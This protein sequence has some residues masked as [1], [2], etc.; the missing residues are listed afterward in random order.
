MEPST[1]MR[2]SRIRLTAIAITLS[3]VCAIGGRADDAAP[4]AAKP[5]AVYARVSIGSAS[6]VAKLADDLGIPLPAMLTAGGVEQMFPF[7]GQGGLNPDLPVTMDFVGDGTNLSEAER[8]IWYLPI[9]TGK[10]PISDFFANGEK[11]GDDGALVNGTPFRRT[12]DYLMFG[13][14]RAIMAATKPADMLKNVSDHPLFYA[15]Y[16]PAKFHEANPQLFAQMRNN[17]DQTTKNAANPGEAAGSQMATEFFLGSLDK[18]VFR[19]DRTPEALKLAAQ[20][21]PA[22]QFTAK[23]WPLPGMPDGMA[24]RI[25]WQMP[26]GSLTAFVKFLR[27]ANGDDQFFPPSLNLNTPEKRDRYFE[28]MSDL[29][30]TLFGGE[31]CSTGVA[32]SGSKHKAVDGFVFYVASQSTAPRN[33]ENDCQRLAD[34]LTIWVAKK[35]D[36]KSSVWFT[37]SG[38]RIK[39]LMSCEDDGKP[40]TVIDFVD[41]KGTRLVTISKT[42]NTDMEKLLA[43]KSTGT[44]TTAAAGWV[45]LPALLEMRSCFG[46]PSPALTDADLDVLHKLVA[47][48][49]ISWKVST[50]RDQLDMSMDLPMPLLKNAVANSSQVAELIGR[51]KNN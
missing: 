8:Q 51:L 12:G 6:Q 23:T 4:P 27:K 29:C 50:D 34:E 10:V 9:N 31:Q 47:G 25:D 33:A 40:N 26:A 1:M 49:R 24:A 13:G 28:A 35:D 42:A 41:V 32:R 38:I 5:S 14:T 16:S 44:L 43:A 7:L 2:T 17:A 39:R 36:L 19:I 22:P 37:H 18:M 15:E 45:D 3:A 11:L 20:V 48:Q 21:R 46:T 30:E